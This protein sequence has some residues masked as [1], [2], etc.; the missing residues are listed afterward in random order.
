MGLL[1][2]EPVTGVPVLE[3]SP[4]IVCQALP[5]DGL[6]QFKSLSFHSEVLLAKIEISVHDIHRKA[7]LRVTG[8]I[9]RVDAVPVHHIAFREVTVNEAV[10]QFNVKVI[11]TR[12][13]AILDIRDGISR[14]LNPFVLEL[15][16][17][18]QGFVFYAAQKRSH[19]P[20][21]IRKVCAEDVG[22][23]LSKPALKGR[24]PMCSE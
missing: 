13:V 8:E 12:S 3:D 22:N 7:E 16:S 9:R 14:N 10:N 15:C 1:V 5:A 2:A 11:K 19:Q 23:T 24:F 20:H 6:N 4:H 17:I 18:R 21:G